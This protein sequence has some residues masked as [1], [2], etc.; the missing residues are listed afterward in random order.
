MNFLPHRADLKPKAK[1]NRNNPSE[2]EAKVWYNILHK[3]QLKGYKFLRQKPIGSFIVDFYCSTLRLAIEIDGDSH[4]EQKKY[5]KKRTQSLN[6][7][8]IK[9]VRYTN[10]EVMESLNGIYA[11]LEKQVIIREKE[12]KTSLKKP[13]E[14]ST[15]VE[16]S[17]PLQRGARETTFQT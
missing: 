16:N 17:L 14:F 13:L 5:D 9:I 6:Q 11:D 2:P 12:L 7:L 15:T 4:A 3:R 8:G 10:M 1:T